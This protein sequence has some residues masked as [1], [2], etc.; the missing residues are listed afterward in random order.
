MNT[1]YDDVI[2]HLKTYGSITSRQAFIRYG[3]TRLS[4][5]IHVLKYKRGYNI[6]SEL[7]SSKNRRGATCTYS[8]YKLV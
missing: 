3:I 4:A 5:V 2:N 1:Q 6:K 8:V 7:E